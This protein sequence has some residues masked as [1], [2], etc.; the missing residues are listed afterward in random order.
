MDKRQKLTCE[1]VEKIHE[2]LD[3]GMTLDAIARTHGISSSHVHRIKAAYYRGEVNLKPTSLC[4]IVSLIEQGL[5]FRRRSWPEKLFC[6]YDVEDKWFIQA[7]EETG[8]ELV[9]Y[10]LDLSIEDLAAKD[11]IVLTL[12]IIDHVVNANKK[13]VE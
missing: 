1:Q 3:Q 9:V 11:W 8:C 7:N 4:A 10:R 13:V 6:Y 5:P 2:M 12:E